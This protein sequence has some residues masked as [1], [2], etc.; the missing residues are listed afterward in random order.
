MQKKLAQA[1]EDQQAAFEAK[2]AA[3][4]AEREK[5]RKL[6]EEAER[7]KIAAQEAAKKAAAEAQRKADELEK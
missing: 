7:K 3:D 4:E 2:L 5:Q 6:E 1:L